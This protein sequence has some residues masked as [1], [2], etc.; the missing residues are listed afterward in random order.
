MGSVIHSAYFSDDISEKKNHYHD[1]HQ[2]IFIKKG[3]TAMTINGEEYKAGN[4]DIAIF[5]RYES[6]SIDVL[7]NEY[8]RY[9]LR[10]SPEA[11]NNNN[12]AYSIFLN[13]PSGFRN[14]FNVSGR[15]QGFIDLLDRII[16]ENNNKDKLYDEMLQLL[17]S[18]LLIMIY[19][20]NPEITSSFEHDKFDIIFDLQKKFEQNCKEHYALEA[21]A[22]EYHTSTSTLSHQFKIITGF[23]V[24]EY[25]NSC[26]IATAKY[27]LSKSSL[28]IGGITEECGFSDSSNFSRTFKDKTGITPSQFRKKY[29]I[30]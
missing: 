13:R 17:I 14:I 6:H 5:S 27:Y 18:Q 23:S 26:R 3:L 9:V 2:I 15:Q 19:R 25:L 16:E 22:K 11:M 12:K 28:S 1:C 4:N 8:E 10:I 30:I 21:L 20:A 29:K 24:F 7:S